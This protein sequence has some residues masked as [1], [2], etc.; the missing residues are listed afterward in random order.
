MISMTRDLA[1]WLFVQAQELYMKLLVHLWVVLHESMHAS[2]I[3]TQLT[4][5]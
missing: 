3:L 5:A 4:Q 2:K 1:V